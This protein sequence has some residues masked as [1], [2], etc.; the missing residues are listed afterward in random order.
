MKVVA[1]I[2][3]NDDI[4]VTVPSWAETGSVWERKSELGSRMGENPWKLRPPVTLPVMSRFR[5][6]KSYR[7]PTVL[8]PP[9][10]SRLLASSTLPCCT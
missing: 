5:A 3:S 2:P 9:E 6:P 4:E 1:G 8:S 10:P 7:R